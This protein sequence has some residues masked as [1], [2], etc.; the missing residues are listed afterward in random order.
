[1]S[2]TITKEQHE[3]IIADLNAKWRES[4]EQITKELKLSSPNSIH[5]IKT[6]IHE[7]LPNE[8]KNSG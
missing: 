7:R 5:V 2:E 8:F 3:K 4:V 1:M 6:I